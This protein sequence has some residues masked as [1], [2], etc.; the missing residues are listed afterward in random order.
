MPLRKRAALAVLP[1]QPH[2]RALHEQRPD[3]KRLCGGPID[4]LAE[5]DRRGA[6]GKYFLQQRVHA[7]S[8]WDAARVEPELAQRVLF[9][10]S[11]AQRAE[12]AR[13]LDPGPLRRQPVARVRL[14]VAR[15]K[16]LLTEMRHR[17][18]VHLLAI[19][20]LSQHALRNELARV[21]RERR[22]VALDLLVHER[23]REHRLVQ[24]VVA[25]PPVAKHVDYHVLL[26]PLAVL[27][28]KLA[29]AHHGLDVVAIDMK[30]RDAHRLGDVR[31]V[32][33]RARVTRVGREPNLIVYDHVHGA[34]GCVVAQV[35]Q[36]ERFGHDALP[37]K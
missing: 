35:G 31:R 12:R 19:L 1:A 30:N 32:R 18:F 8:A 7:K 37:S 23:L 11:R 34:A 2:M 36:F 16:K 3:R 29:H 21:D 10:A 25:V 20:L 24:L 27:H 4:R 6:L 15:R 33:R 5:L 26:E 22:R 17:R 14:P 28:R 9:H 13:R